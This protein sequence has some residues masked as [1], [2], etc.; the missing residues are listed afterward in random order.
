MTVKAPAD[1][2]IL[3]VALICT[4]EKNQEWADELQQIPGRGCNKKLQW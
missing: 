1:S 3:T 4:V 2:D